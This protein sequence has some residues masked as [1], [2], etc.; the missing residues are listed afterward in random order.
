MKRAAFNTLFCTQKI[1][2]VKT[3]KNSRMDYFHLIPPI[4]YG[5]RRLYS[6]SCAYALYFHGAIICFF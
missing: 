1:D 4:K 2:Y 5:T 3:P 6:N